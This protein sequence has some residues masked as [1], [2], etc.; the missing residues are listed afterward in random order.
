[1]GFSRLTNSHSFHIFKK[2]LASLLYNAPF[3]LKRVDGVF[4]V[5]MVGIC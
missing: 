3:A 2:G 1:V 5:S 4:I